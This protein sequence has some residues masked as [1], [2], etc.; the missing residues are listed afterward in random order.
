MTTTIAPKIFNGT[1]TIESPKGGH[2]TFRIK[3]QRDSSKFAPGERIVALLTGPDNT[4]SYTSFGFLRDDGTIKL[5]RKRDTDVFQNYAKMLRQFM[6][7]GDDSQ[8]ARMG[9]KCLVSR[10]CRRCNKKLTT[11]ESIEAGIGPECATKEGPV[12]K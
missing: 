2:R 10:C 8:I 9:Y 3:T 11:P 12:L 6:L 5:F 7:L 4:S 1:Y